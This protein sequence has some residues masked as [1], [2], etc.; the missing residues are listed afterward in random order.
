V[1]EDN[2]VAEVHGVRKEVRDRKNIPDMGFDSIANILT[3]KDR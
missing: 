2:W 3:E 1:V